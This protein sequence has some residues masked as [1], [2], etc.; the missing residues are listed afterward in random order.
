[1]DKLYRSVWVS[2]REREGLRLLFERL[3]LDPVFTTASGNTV[4]LATE[5][6]FTYISL[7]LS[8]V[9]ITELGAY[10]QTRLDYYLARADRREAWRQLY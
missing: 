5:R 10:E 4:V 3:G 2:S 6:Q 7:S 1:L 9:Q 8:T